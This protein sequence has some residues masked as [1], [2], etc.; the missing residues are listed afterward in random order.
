M[1]REIFEKEFSHGNSSPPCSVFFLCCVCWYC[2]LVLSPDESP[3]SLSASWD[4]TGRARS[5][6]REVFSINTDPGAIFP[7]YAL[8]ADLDQGQ[9]P[10]SSGLLWG[11]ELRIFLACVQLSP[12]LKLSPRSLRGGGGIQEFTGSRTACSRRS[13]SG[14]RYEGREGEKNKEEKRERALTPTP[15][16][17]CLFVCFFFSAY[18]FFTLSPRSELLEQASE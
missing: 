13:V 11:W 16:P 6:N 7:V 5:S 4:D 17:L 12:P 14:V 3:D 8:L 9:K 10:I 15:S 18:I 1:I 2:G